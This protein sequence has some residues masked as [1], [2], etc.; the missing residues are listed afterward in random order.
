MSDGTDNVFRQ[1][2][3]RRGFMRAFGIGLGAAAGVSLFGCSPSGGGSSD[4]FRIGLIRPT[5]G[6][7]ASSFEPLFIGGE[8]AIKEVNDA[9]GIRGKKIE[10]VEIDDQG[11]PAQQPAVARKLNQDGIQYILGPVGTS[12]ALASVAVTGPYKI[13]QSTYSNGATLGDGAA[14]PYAFQTSFNTT[15]QGYAAVTHLTQGLDVE[16]IAVLAESTAF[17]DDALAA[18]EAELDKI[19]LKPLRVER[20]S[21]DATSLDAQVKALYDTGAD[22]VVAWIANIPNGALAFN[23]MHNLGW[24]PQVA[25][26]SGLFGE[27]IF[28][29]VPDQAI[30]NVYGTYVKNFTWSDTEEPTD[31]AKEF[32]AKLAEYPAAEGFEP[33]IVSAPFYDFVHILKEVIEDIDSED[34]A[35]VQEALNEL[36]DYDGLLGKISFTED[37]HAGLDPEAVALASVASAKDPKAQGAFRLRVPGV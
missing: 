2:F 34:P 24:Y 15:Q 14:Y 7:L 33:P 36:E 16:K 11:S 8:I 25:G 17:G 10:V 23:A 31:R 19:N 37:N 12:Q 27:S 26:H 1:P 28:D 5:T 9:G 21:V 30:E 32:A 18:T 6:K 35:D 3:G 22:A 4:A 20:Y 13:V 29:L